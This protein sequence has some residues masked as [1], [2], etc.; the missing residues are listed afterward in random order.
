MS[1]VETL[2]AGR[3]LSDLI[4]IDA[5]AHVGPWQSFYAPNPT[6]QQMLCEM[7]RHGIAACCVSSLLSIA[8]DIQRGN[9][10]VATMMREAQ[11]RFYGYIT[12][13]PNLP[14]EE[15]RKELQTRL[16]MDIGFIGIKLHPMWHGHPING[17]LYRPLWDLAA[18]MCPLVLGHSW[19]GKEEPENYNTPALYAEMAE[20]YPEVTVI[21]G[22]SGGTFQGH[23]EA[24]RHC[25]R[26]K[27]LYTDICA[28][29]FSGLWM[30]EFLKVVP[31]EKVLF[32]TDMP[33]LGPGS[34]IGR[35]GYA[36]ITEETKR[37]IF[38]GNMAAILLELDYIK[39]EIKK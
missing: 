9:D 4:V 7:D 5:H 34:P 3:G 33:F 6:S 14:V 16:E 32:A 39:G 31:P 22:H 36:G 17:D 19:L 23:M 15:N 26:L 10:E 18:E 24:A 30:E 35:I 28:G 21:M 38:G 20:R 29:E 11:G 25:S 2:W 37:A 27:N 1:L 8:M 12:L 13:N